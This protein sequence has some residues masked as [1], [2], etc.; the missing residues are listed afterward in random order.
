MSVLVVVC[1]LDSFN[2]FLTLWLWLRLLFTRIRLWFLIGD[3]LR[4]KL[5]EALRHILEVLIAMQFAFAASCGAR[6]SQSRALLL[7]HLLQ[8][9]PE[10]QNPV[11]LPP[12]LLDF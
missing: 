4:F 10:Q 2:R 7:D 9:E 5:L 1:Q 12:Q 11:R 6:W 8:L 3:D